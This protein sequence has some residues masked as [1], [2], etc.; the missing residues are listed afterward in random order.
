MKVTSVGRTEQIFL[1]AT[2]YFSPGQMEVKLI[3]YLLF[4]KQS[5]NGMK[6]MLYTKSA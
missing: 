6:T 4:C 1:K 2:V 5:I 3:L